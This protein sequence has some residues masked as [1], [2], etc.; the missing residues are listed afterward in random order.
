LGNITVRRFWNIGFCGV[1]WLAISTPALAGCGP[2]ELERGTVSQ[3]TSDGD[4]VLSD[5]R[6]LRLAGLHMKPD[7]VTSVL[8]AGDQLAFGLISESKDRWSRHGA[9][10][11]RLEGEKPPEWLQHKLLSQKQALV[12]PELDLGD[13]WALLKQTEA[14]FRKNLP[15]LAQEGGRFARTEGKVLRVGEGRS[16]HFINLVDPSG[17]RI[18]GLVQK[19]YLRRFKDA[20]VDV[21]Q[22]RGQFIRLRGVRSVRNI[23]VLPLTMVEQIEIVR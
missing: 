3:I 1:I 17:E 14:E 22:L 4:I 20:G 5:S 9:M 12:R 16:A 2:S 6:R 8:T 10:V 18:T 13:C 19:R 23:S 21:S 11:F 15:A 7:A